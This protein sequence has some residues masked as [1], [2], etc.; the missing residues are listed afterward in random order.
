MLVE[1]VNAVEALPTLGRKPPKV[2]VCVVTYNQEK[3]IAH[4]LQSIVDQETNFE[5][6]VIV[7]DDA[8]TDKTAEIIK[9]YQEKYPHLIT[10]KIRSLNIGA[11]ANIFSIYAMAKG[12]YIAHIDGDDFALPGKLQAQVDALE[13]NPDCVI[14]SHDVVR[15]SCDIILY[16]HS[17]SDSRDVKKNL[18]DLY[19]KLPFFAH[20]SKMFLN[21]YGDGFFKKFTSQATDFELHIEQARFGNIIHLHNFLGGYNSHV[22]VSFVGGRVNPALVSSK[23][24]VFE[25]EILRTTSVNKRERLMSA[26]ARSILSYA[27]QS[28]KFGNNADCRAYARDSMRIKYVSSL[29]WLI[30]L[31]GFSSFASKLSYRLREKFIQ[32]RYR[33]MPR[34]IK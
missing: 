6:E 15:V 7:G 28:A 18:M 10:A 4:C 14:C 11:I 27:Y 8:S 22:G 17:F 30:Y 23:R 12:K 13:K 19:E 3:Y 5:F 34:N 32:L 20:S 33:R 31:A 16:K 21:A 25:E 9:F 1:S 24:R 29:Q 2:S 26:Y